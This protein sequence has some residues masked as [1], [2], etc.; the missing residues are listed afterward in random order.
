MPDRV[1][2]DA[3]VL[4]KA[5]ARRLSTGSRFLSPVTTTVIV[6]PRGVLKVVQDA[7]ASPEQI[8]LWIEEVE[9]ARS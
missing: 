6:D 1:L 3:E 5:I 2:I 9:N 4:V 7:G 8:D